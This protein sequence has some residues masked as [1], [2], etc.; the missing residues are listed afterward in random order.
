MDGLSTTDAG[1]LFIGIIL[2][3]REVFAFVMKRRN[4]GFH[5]EI[6]CAECV[7][8]MRKSGKQ[9][10]DLHDWHNVRDNEGKPIW[11]ARKSL[12]VAIEKL[13]E[14]VNQQTKAIERQSVILER[15]SQ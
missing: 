1:I 8:L 4:G 3:L 7:Q 6:L 9:V 14:N 15:I 5:P 2:I 10:E 13:S 12:E 11:Y